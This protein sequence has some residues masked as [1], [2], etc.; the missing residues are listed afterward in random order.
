[1]TFCFVSGSWRQSCWMWRGKGQNVAV[2]DT[3]SGVVADARRLWADW[4]FSPASVRC[5]ITT[6]VETAEQSSPKDPG[7]AVCVPK[8]RKRLFC[9]F[10]PLTKYCILANIVSGSKQSGVFRV[11]IYIYTILSRINLLLVSSVH[12]ICCQYLFLNP[13]FKWWMIYIGF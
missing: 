6:C 12:G 10:S 7:C 5:V 4:L 1:M 13:S 8:S 11:Y 9:L 3:V 2:E